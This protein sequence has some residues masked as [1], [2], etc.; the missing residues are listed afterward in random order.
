MKLF[1]I[2]SAV[3]IGFAYPPETIE[4]IPDEFTAEAFIRRGIAVEAPE[5]FTP[6]PKD[7]PHRQ[8]YIESGYIDFE[9]LK[10]LPK[11]HSLNGMNNFY[12]F[13][14]PK[15]RKLLSEYLDQSNKKQPKK[16]IIY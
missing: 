16:N 11:E 4:E 9:K 5:K 8:Q 12:G 13:S 1:F 15:T 10:A 3:P 2:K 7:F 14:F 6:L